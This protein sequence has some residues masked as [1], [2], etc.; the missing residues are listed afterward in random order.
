MEEKELVLSP[1][2]S[3]LMIRD[4]DI[5]KKVLALIV[6]YLRHDY[7][8]VSAQRVQMND[9]VLGVIR[10][11]PSSVCLSS[12]DVCPFEPAF[13]KYEDENFHRFHSLWVL[14]KTDNSCREPRIWFMF[15]G[16]YRTWFFP[17]QG[18]KEIA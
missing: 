8:K 11:Y 15:P 10:K 2:V 1:A 13:A 5:E 17:L 6:R 16:E 9:M 12:N 18:R 3:E 7:G 14:E 4:R